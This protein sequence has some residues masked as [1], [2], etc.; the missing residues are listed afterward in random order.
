[1]VCS[2]MDDVG[3]AGDHSLCYVSCSVLRIRVYIYIYIY[4]YIHIYVYVSKP[5]LPS[6]NLFVEFE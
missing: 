4:I 5:Q 6:T 1:M 2:R 3:Q